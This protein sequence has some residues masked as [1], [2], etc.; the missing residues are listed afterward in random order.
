MREG[1]VPPK[2]ADRFYKI[3]FDA[4][5]MPILSLFPV[6]EQLEQSSVDINI[7]GLKC[8]PATIRWSD[9]AK[10]PR[11]KMRAPLICQIFNWVEEVEWEGIRLCDFLDSAGLDTHPEGYFGVYSRDGHYF[12]GLTREMARDGRTLL[13]TGL[14]GAPLPADHGGPVRL[15]VP[16]LQ[17]YKSVKWVSAIRATRHDPMGI[18]RLLAQ[19]KTGHLGT[20]WRNRYGLDFAYN[21]RPV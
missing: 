12:E 3:D 10:L 2:F 7:C 18:K 20:T 4:N 8:Q 1:I 6:P 11:V 13:A 14:N 19:S 17:G 16:F 21:G 15:V 5:P 9:C